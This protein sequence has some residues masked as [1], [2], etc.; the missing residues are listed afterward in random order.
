MN[1]WKFVCLQSLGEK[2]LEECE[3]KSKIGT[4]GH[5]Y[6]YGDLD[7]EGWGVG[8]LLGSGEYTDF[9]SEHLEDGFGCGYLQEDVVYGYPSGNGTSTR[10][11]T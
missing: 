11:V 5:G 6:A 10:E 2:I 8:D 3:L 1:T 4:D 9:S 7:G